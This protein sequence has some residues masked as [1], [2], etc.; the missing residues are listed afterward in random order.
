M[1][2]PAGFYGSNLTMNRSFLITFLLIGLY[3]QRLEAE[4]ALYPFGGQ[5]GS[6]FE[7]EVVGGIIEGASGAFFNSESLEATA[8]VEVED[9]SPHVYLDIIIGP[10]AEV[11]SHILKVISPKG[12]SEPIPIQ[13]S[14]E[15][16]ILESEN[17]HQTAG[18]AQ[19]VTHPIVIN[20][21]LSKWGELDYYA[22]EV[23]A[24]EELMFEVITSSGLVNTG[25]SRAPEQLND[26]ELFLYQATGSWFDPQ[27]A[28]RLEPIDESLVYY[29]PPR[30]SAYSMP[31]HIPRLKHQFEEAGWY[32]LE[33]GCVRHVGGPTFTYQLRVASTTVSDGTEANS[34][35]PR[36][37]ARIDPFEWCERDYRAP[38]ETDRL[39]EIQDRTVWG[40]VDQTTGELAIVAEIEPTEATAE[41]QVVTVPSIIEGTIDSPGDV[42]TFRFKTTKKDQKLAFEI[43]TLDTFPP[44]F[45]PRLTVS[46]SNEERLFTNIFRKVGGDGDDWDKS[47]EPKCVFTFEDKDEYLVQIRDLTSRRGGPDYRYQL[48]VRPQIPHVGEIGAMELAQTGRVRYGLHSV[49]VP[50]GKSAKLSV[51]TER[52]EGFIGEVALT[53]EN[54]PEGVRAYPAI[55]D[56]PDVSLTGGVYEQ[57]GVVE[58]ERYRPKRQVNSILLIADQTEAATT[59][60]PQLIRLTATPILNNISG[61][62]FPIQEIPLMV[63]K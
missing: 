8:R 46:A 47:I 52:E 6:H 30:T 56:E 24:G 11:G 15:P 53:V 54:L 36:E 17:P 10:T 42:D 37:L 20:G 63:V 23:D 62:T 57:R 45:S 38:I 49:S 32:L 51:V 26:S 19:P 29:Y 33:V 12:L 9:G 31:I 48:L 58:K 18:T 7:A 22:I 59:T 1:A 40:Q 44:Y 41:L 28:T 21:R 16:T 25:L 27:R 2:Y 60:E 5:Q 3:A 61:K 43:R 13:V 34:W 50:L 4:L 35:T 39:R 14:S 55:A